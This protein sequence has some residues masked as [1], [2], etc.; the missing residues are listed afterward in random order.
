MVI[1]YG[2]SRKLTH[3]SKLKINLAGM[4]KKRKY[5]RKCPQKGRKCILQRVGTKGVH[6]P[7]HMGFKALWERLEGGD[8]RC[9]KMKL[10]MKQYG[11]EKEWPVVF[12]SLSPCQAQYIISAQ[13]L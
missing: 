7:W 12:S 13:C 3:M 2:S 10:L 5:S 4:R 8:H 11:D 9:V 1:C 6:L